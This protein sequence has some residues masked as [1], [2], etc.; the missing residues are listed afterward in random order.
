MKQLLENELLESVRLLHG[1][2]CKATAVDLRADSR[3]LLKSVHSTGRSK[4]NL[5]FGQFRSRAGRP[6]TYEVVCT[7]LGREFSDHDSVQAAE[8]PHRWR[9]R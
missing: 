2:E 6:L 1:G 7:T 8:L 4:A 3:I 5:L 9:S